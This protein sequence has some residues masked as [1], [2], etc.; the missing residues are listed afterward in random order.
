MNKVVHLK[1]VIISKYHFYPVNTTTQGH[2]S[3]YTFSF[4]DIP[5]FP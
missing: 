2:G 5:V 3:K 4:Q 1:K